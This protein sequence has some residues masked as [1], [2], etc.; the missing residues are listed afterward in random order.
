MRYTLESPSV[1]ILYLCGKRF[2]K[3]GRFL[4]KI[5]DAAVPGEGIIH[6]TVTTLRHTGLLLHKKN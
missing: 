4:C 5:Q 3:K 2:C 1:H 6:K